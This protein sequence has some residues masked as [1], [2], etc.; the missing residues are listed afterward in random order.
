MR[1]VILLFVLT[2]ML[3]V[4]A[5]VTATPERVTIDVNPIY[6]SGITGKARLDAQTPATTSINL[7]LR[8]LTPGE[9]YVSLYYANYFCTFEPNS[10]DKV[11]GAY[12]GNPSGNA[13]LVKSAPTPLDEI[14]SVS[15]R[16]ASDYTLLA[17][18]VI[19]SSPYPP[20]YP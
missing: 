7:S 2:S 10:A 5:K 1:K 15:V 16:R 9:Q 3:F 12:T 4:A 6:N 17:C 8:G 20:P 13:N 18:G 14:K 19:P 11:I